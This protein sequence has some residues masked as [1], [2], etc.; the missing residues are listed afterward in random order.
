MG[1]RLAHSEVAHRAEFLTEHLASDTR[2]DCFATPNDALLTDG[3]EPSAW[4]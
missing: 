1:Q 2:V 4:R 3:K